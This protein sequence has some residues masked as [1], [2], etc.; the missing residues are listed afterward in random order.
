M[1]NQKFTEFRGFV[2]PIFT[3]YNIDGSLNLEILDEYGKYLKEKEVPAILV[4]GSTGSLSS[5]N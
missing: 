3:P 5:I 2:A 1:L 4:N